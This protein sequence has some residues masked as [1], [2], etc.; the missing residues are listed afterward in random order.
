MRSGVYDLT[1]SWPPFPLVL[2]GAG[3]E[4]S[5]RGVPRGGPSRGGGRG[6]LHGAATGAPTPLFAT[7][8]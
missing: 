5:A 2:G 8:P 3:R 7:R 4:N 1:S 6:A